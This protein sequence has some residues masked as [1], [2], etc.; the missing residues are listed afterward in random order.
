MS[1]SFKSESSFA[2]PASAARQQKFKG[3][4]KVRGGSRNDKFELLS[5][6]SDGFDFSEA[7]FDS[8]NN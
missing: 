5:L 1:K 4:K 6:A 8:D 3:S 2:P 7:D